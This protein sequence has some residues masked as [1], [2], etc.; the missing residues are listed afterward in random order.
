MPIQSLLRR[1]LARFRRPRSAEPAATSRALRSIRTEQRRQL[2]LLLRTQ[3]AVDALVRRAYIDP[4][5]LDYPQRLTA[6]RFGI[7]SQNAEDGILLALLRE[8][9]RA[10]DR[11]V[12]IGCG[13][14]GGNSGFLAV[15][16]GFS[17]LMLDASDEA[18]AEA[19]LRFNPARVAIELAFVSRNNVNELIERHGLG[20]EIDVLSIDIDSNDL[21]VWE[22][23]TACS[24]R[25]VVA[26]YNALFG[27]ERSVA[28]PYDVATSGVPGYHGASLAAFA[29]V[30]KRKG[31]RL[32]AVEQR[33]ANAFF[34]RGD[35]ATH[36]PECEPAA[37]FAPLVP[38]RL[39]YAE[40]GESKARKVLSE[41]AEL[42]AR[43]RENGLPLV[44]I[45]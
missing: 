30:G 5:S 11:F 37:V 42:E 2:E 22:A 39:L 17:G 12:E 23:V 8:G 21:W 45:S 38:T 16:L 43:M 6:Q 44:E 41:P 9:G 19:R 3:R 10:T 35:V 28:V 13:H 33:G 27:P 15:E 18:L 14:N 26:E 7:L 4:E 31:Y 36:V 40:A 20:G 29:T 25:I 34:L 24:P 32:V 1:L